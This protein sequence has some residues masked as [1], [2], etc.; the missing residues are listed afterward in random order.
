MKFI[1]FLFLFLSINSMAAYI[2]IGDINSCGEKSYYSNIKKCG[3]DCIKVNDSFNCEYAAIIP[4]T[5]MKK[6]IESCSDENDCQSKLESK[7]CEKGIAIKNLDS[8]EVYCTWL[9]P[10]HV[11]INKDKKA[12]FDQKEIEKEQER[13]D[14]KA[15]VQE[16]KGYIQTINESELPAWHK[17]I[18]RKLVRDLKE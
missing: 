13:A 7:S 4:E 8:M 9:R 2:K 14:R 10:E 15:D 5:Q 11:G 17:K 3:N 1:I 16:L 6:E 12:I 18:L